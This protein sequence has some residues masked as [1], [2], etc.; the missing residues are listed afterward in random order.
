MDSEEE[1]A[2]A[3][4]PKLKSPPPPMPRKSPA[5]TNAK[6]IQVAKAAPT[7]LDPEMIAHLGGWATV[8]NRRSSRKGK[9]VPIATVKTEADLDRVIAQNPYLKN[10]SK[11][12]LNR[13]LSSMPEALR[14]GANEVLC[15]VGS[16]STMNAAWI[17]KQFPAYAKLIQSTAASRRGESAVTANGS[18]LYEKGG[19]SISGS[20]NSQPATIDFKDMEVEIPILSV[21]KMIKKRNQVHFDEGGGFIENKDTGT[22]VP[23]YEYAGAYYLKLCVHDPKPIHQLLGS[24]RQP[25]F[26]RLGR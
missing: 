18:K 23:F 11:K 4:F 10:L 2:R 9:P 13:V 24:N 17:E 5:E 19:V 16:G 22:R 15:L 6:A 21:R 20:V 14:C 3:D 7:P 8:V 12:R 26:H 1:D 25:D